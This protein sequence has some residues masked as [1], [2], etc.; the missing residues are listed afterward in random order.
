MTFPLKRPSHPL[1][2]VAHL[3]VV[4][5]IAGRRTRTPRI[6]RRRL[7]VRRTVSSAALSVVAARSPFAPLDSVVP[8][9]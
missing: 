7:R 6:H 1:L 5:E 8:H 2:S 9:G 3:A 4:C